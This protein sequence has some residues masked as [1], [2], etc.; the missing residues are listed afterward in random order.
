MTFDLIVKLEKKF[1]CILKSSHE[2]NETEHVK[3]EKN[4][5]FGGQA[6]QTP[7]QHH[8]ISHSLRY[9]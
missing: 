4:C 9:V 1:M 2:T 7:L 3:P 5:L 6:P 8:T